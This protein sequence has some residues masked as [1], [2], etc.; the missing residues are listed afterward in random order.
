MF[1]GFDERVSVRGIPE[2]VA[3]V[4]AESKIEFGVIDSLGFPEPDRMVAAQPLEL[5]ELSFNESEGVGLPR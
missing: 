5:S 2:A 3:A 4:N 1:D